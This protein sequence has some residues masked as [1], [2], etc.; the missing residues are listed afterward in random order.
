M[1]MILLN[2]LY[3]IFQIESALQ[4][5]IFTETERSAILVTRPTSGKLLSGIRTWENQ[6]KRVIPLIKRIRYSHTC[7]DEFIQT[8]DFFDFKVSLQ[9][10][11]ERTAHG[12]S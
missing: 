5:A 4:E 11:V 3:R 1:I 6:T 9:K 10:S 7:R 12:K 8:G 2:V